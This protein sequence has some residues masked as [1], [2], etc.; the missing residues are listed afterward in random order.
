MECP[1]T[2]IQH[3]TAF[4]A[5]HSHENGR[6]ITVPITTDASGA[7]T[8][9]LLSTVPLEKHLLTKLIITLKM[10]AACTSEMS[11]AL[12]TSIKPNSRININK[13]QII[14]ILGNVQ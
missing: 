4:H 2:A 1:K 13:L 8:T 14:N 7:L 3:L 9:I 12:T 5:L 10:E 11:A 6:L